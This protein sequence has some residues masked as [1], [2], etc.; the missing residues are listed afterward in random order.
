M[1]FKVAADVRSARQRHKSKAVGCGVRRKT[2]KEIAGGDFGGK[3]I[4]GKGMYGSG[5]HH[6]TA[7][8]MRVRLSD[9]LSRGLCRVAAA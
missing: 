6:V 4:A 5:I 9:P 8:A 2:G 1:S 7:G 3:R